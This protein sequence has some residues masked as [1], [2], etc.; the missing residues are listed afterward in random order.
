MPTDFVRQNSPGILRRGKL[1]HRLKLLG[2]T[3]GL[4]LI[5][6][7]KKKSWRNIMFK[8]TYVGE[9]TL[10]Q[11]HMA[12]METWKMAGWPNCF[13]VFV[14]SFPVH[15][16]S[17]EHSRSTSSFSMCR[18]STTVRS[19]ESIST[20]TRI[21]WGLCEALSDI[22]IRAPTADAAVGETEGQSF[23]FTCWLTGV[24]HNIQ[25]NRCL[26]EIKCY[27]QGWTLCKHM[28]AH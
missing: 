28:L 9:A 10:F 17:L 13:S 5:K 22:Q 19:T 26:P 11:G 14:S 1:R 4:K 25:I 24:G 15:S 27:I 16:S 21:W 2:K 3:R 7:K 12:A 6:R 8:N 18:V 20:L 23:P